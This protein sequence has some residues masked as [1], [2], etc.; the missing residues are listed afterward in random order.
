MAI[1]TKILGPSLKNYVMEIEKGIDNARITLGTDL[2]N[3]LPH[4]DGLAILLDFFF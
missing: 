4:Q 3:P 2:I 1:E